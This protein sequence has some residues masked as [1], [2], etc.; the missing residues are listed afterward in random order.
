M[1][2]LGSKI[3]SEV[4]SEMGRNQREYLLREQLKAIRKELGENDDQAKELEELRRKI[5]T[6]G[7]PEPSLKE[8]LRELDRLSRMPVAA[9]EYTVSR[10]YIDWLIALPWNRRTEE[11]IDLAHTREILDGD[12]SGLEKAKDRILEYL[13]VRKLN[14]GHEG[15]D[16]LF[17]R[18]R[19]GWARHRWPRASPR[20]STGSSF[21]SRWAA[22]GT[23]PRSA[24]TA[25]LYRRPAGTD[26][27]GT[28]P[29]RVEEPGVHPRRNRQAGDGLPRRPGFRAARSARSRAEPGVS[30]SLRRSAVRT[31]PEVLF[32]HDG[33]RSRSDSAGVAGPDGGARAA[34][35]TE[36]EK[37][38]IATEHLLGRQIENHGLTAEQ[39]GF[40]EEALRALIRGYTREA[41]CA[42]SNARSAALCRKV[43][44]PAGR[45]AP[46][47]RSRSRRRR[48]SRCWAHRNISMKR[49]RNVR[50]VPAWPSV[51]RGR[52]WAVTCSSS[53]AADE[54]RRRADPDRAPRATS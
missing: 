14:P 28:P 40:T 13:A 54:W 44:P 41:G 29:R 25:Y 45:G 42:T 50:S 20:P 7:M 27:A 51:W 49:S 35:Y 52:R 15:T 37:L 53:K 8:A 36:E 38:V 24:A 10:T 30:R 4:Q 1:L 26:H 34:R 16:S 32:H 31:F 5:E 33:E 11:R 19:P 9:A 47:R 21:A 17:R 6:A 18:S 2:E 12:H 43:G 46:N 39:V 48:S 23:R 22:C 3:Q